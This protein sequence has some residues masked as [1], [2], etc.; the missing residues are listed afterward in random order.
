VT[1]IIIH[2]L[3]YKIKDIALKDILVHCAKLVITMETYGENNMLKPAHM[4]IKHVIP[5]VLWVSNKNSKFSY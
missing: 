2:A 4:L 1:V 5:V 3:E